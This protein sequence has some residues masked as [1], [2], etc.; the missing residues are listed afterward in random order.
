MYQKILVPMALDHGICAR[1]IDKVYLS[2]PLHGDVHHLNL[3][4][5]RFM[6]VFFP[7]SQEGDVA[8]GWGHAFGKHGATQQRIEKC[9]LAGIELTHHNQ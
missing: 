5:R 4:G 9:S 8:C 6:A 1:R 2:Q 7:V 3:I